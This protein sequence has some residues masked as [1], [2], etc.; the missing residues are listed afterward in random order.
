MEG[1]H[2]DRKVPA[3]GTGPQPPV[4]DRTFFLIQV[5]NFKVGMVVFELYNDQVPITCKNFRVLC[6]GMAGRV[7]RPCGTIDKLHYRGTRVHSII[8]EFIIQAGDITKGDGTG[9]ASIYANGTETF[10]S[11]G[12]DQENLGWRQIDSAGLLC[13]ANRGGSKSNTSQ[14][15]ITLSP[16]HYLTNLYTV[17]GH[18]IDGMEIIEEIGKIEVG[19]KDYPK[20]KIEILESGELTPLGQVRVLSPP[21]A[22]RCRPPQNTPVML[23]QPKPAS[24]TGASG[25]KRTHSKQATALGARQEAVAA[26]RGDADE[27]RHPKRRVVMFT[28][29]DEDYDMDQGG[30]ST[31]R[32]ARNYLGPRSSLNEAYQPNRRRRLNHGRPLLAKRSRRCYPYPR[33][34]N[35]GEG[36]INEEEGREIPKHQG[37]R[38]QNFL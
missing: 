23:P 9:G 32:F 27:N 15:F 35:E 3:A 2:Q 10:D 4:R 13:M 20:V 28:R 5:N 14:F 36:N 11:Q 17:F 25:H 22:I 1:I 18:V 21:V 34:S 37:F 8:K 24:N 38:H 7:T 6:T 19:Y 16:A 30:P 29:G 31:Q 26:G 12:F 33:N